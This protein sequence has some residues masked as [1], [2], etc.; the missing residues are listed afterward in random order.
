M[1]HT[2]FAGLK[3]S[4]NF[5]HS[6]I[7]R[8]A[9]SDEVDDEFLQLLFETGSFGLLPKDL[10]GRLGQF[11]ITRHQVSRRIMRMNKRVEKVIGGQVAEQKRLALGYDKLCERKLGK[12]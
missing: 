9:C 6:L 10:A 11:N 5:D 8:I 1:L 12:N 7:E 2:I 3:G 4:F